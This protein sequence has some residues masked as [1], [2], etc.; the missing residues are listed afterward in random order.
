MLKISQFVCIVFLVSLLSNDKES[1]GEIPSA[2]FRSPVDIQCLAAPSR[3]LGQAAAA[4]GSSAVA[5]SSRQSG[6]KPGLTQQQ[7]NSI[8]K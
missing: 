8:L 6:S 2:V 7:A 4:A 5:N 1:H 3:H